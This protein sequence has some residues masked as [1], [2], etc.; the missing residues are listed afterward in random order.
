MSQAAVAITFSKEQEQIL[1]IAGVM[2][3]AGLPP[4]FV[5]RAL[6]M[7]FEYEGAYDLLTLWIEESSAEERANIIA[8]LEEQ[9]TDLRDYELSERGAAKPKA[10]PKINFDDIP[11]IGQDIVAFKKRLRGVVDSNGGVAHLAAKTGMSEPSLYRFFNSASIPRKTTLYKIA[12][13]LDIEEK[14]IAVKYSK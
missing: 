14:D 3:H 11:A 10:R 12:N 9:I 2:L 4:R 13:A 8:D 7:A 1:R 5:Q 6:E